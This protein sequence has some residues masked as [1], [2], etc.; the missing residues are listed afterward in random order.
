MITVEKILLPQTKA[1]H[2]TLYLALQHFMCQ[3]AYMS[4]ATVVVIIRRTS[5]F[6]SWPPTIVVECYMKWYFTFAFSE[7]CCH[8]FLDVFINPINR[9]VIFL[10]PFNFWTI[11][12]SHPQN[13]YPF[14][15][16]LI[17]NPMHEKKFL[18]GQEWANEDIQMKIMTIFYFNLT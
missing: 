6:K 3:I 10:H 17:W 9:N 15:E 18:F 14:L 7:L 8:Y 1:F 16:W 2:K 5:L 11:H 12:R 4:V 13:M